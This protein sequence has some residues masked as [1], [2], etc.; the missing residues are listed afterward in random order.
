MLTS[1]SFTDA[2]FETMSGL[3]TTGATV[4]VG[5]DAAAG[6]QPV[7]ARAQLAGRHGHHRAGGGDPKPLLGVGGM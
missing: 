1:L 7:A 6:H 2:F 4:L 3:T 5:L